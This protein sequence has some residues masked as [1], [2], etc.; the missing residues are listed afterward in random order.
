MAKEITLYT[1]NGFGWSFRKGARL[2]ISV[3]PSALYVGGAFTVTI[4][5]PAGC[6]LSTV[7][8]T[9]G[10]T[11]IALTG[12]GNTRTGT[13]PAE[14]GPLVVTATGADADGKPLTATRTVQV[15]EE[16]PSPGDFIMS[17]L[18]VSRVYQRD[19][20]TGGDF[21][22]G[23]GVIPIDVTAS[24]ATPVYARLRD[25]VTGD[26]IKA[27]W[28]VGNVT[29]GASTL[30]VAGIPARRGRCYVDLAAEAGGPWQEGTTPVAM[31]AIIAGGGQ[32][33][34]G[35]TAYANG[36]GTLASLGIT[37]PDDGFISWHARDSADAQDWTDGTW[38]RPAD[39]G[40]YTGSFAG[41]ILQDMTVALGVAV[42]YVGY[43]RGTTKASDFA[44]GS[45][46]RNRL[47]AQLDMAGGF[48]AFL[49]VQGG[50]DMSSSTPP[51]TFKAA[52]Q[53]VLDS[54][55]AH[56]AIRGS[57]FRLIGS[58]TFTRTSSTTVNSNNMRRAVQE[59]MTQLGGTYMDTRDI[60]LTDGIHQSQAGGQR[61]ARHVRRALLQDWHPP[62]PVSATKA[63]AVITVACDLSDGA[64]LA[65]TGVPTNKVRVEQ[66]GTAL[67]IASVAASGSNLTITLSADPGDVD[68]DV[69]IYPSPDPSNAAATAI[70][71]DNSAPVGRPAQPNYNALIAQAGGGSSL[72]VEGGNGQATVTS[73][74]TLTSPAA[75]GGAGQITV[76]NY[77]A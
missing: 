54:L 2:S 34:M 30:D 74:D 61:F 11:P 73:Y 39:D 44:A 52:T 13:A 63:G 56:N 67:T 16:P 68:L 76:T 58:A 25:A 43:S 28:Q 59:L 24:A 27:A 21:G 53:D 64:T 1:E 41:Q 70:I 29:E 3:S 48:E 18:A 10:G 62:V 23:A 72:A 15:R 65:L 51:A 40:Q 26:V 4:A 47:H 14:A 38:G 17:Q 57:N 6:T 19:T 31:G 45:A 75:V 66:A 49:W 32:S 33:Q 36:A 22:R 55:P 77:G 69:W 9:A 5:V 71:A 12:S 8:A 46:D 60:I 50:T 35:Y 42:G 20:D 37:V 7:T